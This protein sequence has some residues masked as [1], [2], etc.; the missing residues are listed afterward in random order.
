MY[1]LLHPL[2][3]SLLPGGLSTE[4][5]RA[6]ARDG[7]AAP[8]R[9]PARRGPVRARWVGID[10]G[11]GKDPTTPHCAHP[12]RNRAAA[13]SA[14]C[15]AR[16]TARGTGGNSTQATRGLASKGCQASES[17]TP[18][19]Q[20]HWGFLLFV[21][22]VCTGRGGK[23]DDAAPRRR[24]EDVNQLGTRTR[25]RGAGAEEDDHRREHLPCLRTPL[26]RA[27]HDSIA[28]PP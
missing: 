24:E 13:P 28:A 26:H 14:T 5:H 8:A 15:P 21:T 23:G 25:G 11:G 19:H 4:P 27:G 1:S 16:R 20:P 6:M 2:S 17:R 7:T 18:S 10:C 22:F 9:R 3:S 12:R